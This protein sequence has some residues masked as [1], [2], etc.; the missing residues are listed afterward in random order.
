VQIVHVPAF[1]EFLFA[2]PFF[3]A[4]F[5]LFCQCL[6]VASFAS[7]LMFSSMYVVLKGVV[8]A[9]SHVC[10]PDGIVFQCLL[11]ELVMR[12]GLRRFVTRAGCLAALVV[13]SLHVLLGVPLQEAVHMLAVVLPSAQAFWSRAEVGLG[14]GSSFLRHCSSSL[15]VGFLAGVAAFGIELLRQFRTY[16]KNHTLDRVLDY[17]PRKTVKGEKEGREKERRSVTASASSN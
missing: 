12:C 15:A 7:L 11:L 5:P 8:F 16:Q 10:D 13:M 1:T 9:L 6:S 4:L 17:V 3:Q 14:F 2:K